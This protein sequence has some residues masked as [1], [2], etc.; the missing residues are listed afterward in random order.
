[1]ARRSAR[2]EDRSSARPAGAAV[3][4]LGP[5]RLH[6]EVVLVAGAVAIAVGPWWGLALVGAVLC[7]ELGHAMS[8]A[9]W[10]APGA[11]LGVRVQL[12]GGGA[13]LGAQVRPVRDAV[14]LVGGT[15]L[16]LALGWGL[17]TLLALG[18]RAPSAPLA[19][20]LPPTVV[21]WSVFQLLPFPPLDGGTLLVRVLGPRLGRRR[22]WWLGWGLGAA[23]WAA[24][25]LL[26]PSAREPAVWLAGLAVVLGR[27]EAAHLTALEVYD[28][29]AAGH[30]GL[31]VDRAEAAMDRLPTAQRREVARVGLHAAL[32][33]GRGEGVGAL[34]ARLPPGDPAALEAITWLLGRDMDAGGVE[35][36]RL[37]DAVDAERVGGIPDD[38]YADLCLYHAIHEARRLRPE[39]AIGLLERAV[40]HGLDARTRV[41]A[42]PAF[43]ALADRPR[44]RQ[45]VARMSEDS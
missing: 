24:L 45:V 5:I 12:G 10:P 25:V 13:Y 29:Y 8:S 44:Y 11:E 14:V 17:A 42:E 4:A 43:A 3:W 18:P 33:R 23:T 6:A 7:H 30:W 20:V 2:S 21:L 41:T 1:M 27:S 39:S 40:D 22:T 35:A 28:A 9:L 15:A 32:E 26:V 34:V 31:A 19:R 37:H 38:V 16:G 36:E